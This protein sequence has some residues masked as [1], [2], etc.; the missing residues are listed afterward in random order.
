MEENTIA[1]NDVI[2]EIDV[3]AEEK[4]KKASFMK[5]TSLDRL[6]SGRDAKIS[7]RESQIG[8]NV[9]HTDKKVQIDI[10]KQANRYNKTTDKVKGLINMEE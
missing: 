2:V 3:I 1:E 6:E 8:P 9:S 5:V 4:L 7:A 10:D